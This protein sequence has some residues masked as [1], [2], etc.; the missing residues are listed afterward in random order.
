MKSKW[1]TNFLNARFKGKANTDS[2]SSI[3][4]GVSKEEDRPTSIFVFLSAVILIIFIILTGVSIAASTFLDKQTV[5]LTKIL[6]QKESVFQPKLIKSINDFSKQVEGIK[7]LQ[8][9]QSN[10]LP[11][12]TTTFSLATPSTQYTK[13]SLNRI[14]VDLYS[15]SIFATT[16]SLPGYLQ[17]LRGFQKV[18]VLEEQKISSVRIG[19]NQIVLFSMNGK[20]SPSALIKDNSTFYTE[21][22]SGDILNI[23]GIEQTRENIIEGG[24]I[25]KEEEK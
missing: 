1:T 3:D 12:L 7:K 11:I 6:E 13:L 2:V 22:E 8:T 9:K 14:G 19:E 25:G 20:I 24:S 4:L 21:D 23:E 17:Q 5:E 16:Q 15:V 10:I 18:D